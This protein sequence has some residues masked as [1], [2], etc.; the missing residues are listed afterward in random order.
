[1]K[2]APRP[3]RYKNWPEI[4]CLPDPNMRIIISVCQEPTVLSKLA[5]LYPSCFSNQKKV[6]KIPLSAII[7]LSRYYAA[8]ENFN[9]ARQE[10]HSKYSWQRACSVLGLQTERYRRP[11]TTGK[12]VDPDKKNAFEQLRGQIPT[13]GMEITWNNKRYIVVQ[14]EIRPEEITKPIPDRWVQDNLMLV[15]AEHIDRNS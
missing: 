14:L 4:C 6:P 13:P 10:H 11:N 7:W 8:E 9:A 15:P 12:D 5:E 2:Y 1:M 3:G